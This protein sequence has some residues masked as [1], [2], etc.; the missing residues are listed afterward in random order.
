[1]ADC[2][3]WGI[4]QSSKVKITLFA[5]KWKELKVIKLNKSQT[6]KEKSHVFTQI[7]FW[8]K[9]GGGEQ[10]RNIEETND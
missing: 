10:D 8:K 2:A 1:M 6:Q 5:G 3:Q 9:K 4:I 7:G